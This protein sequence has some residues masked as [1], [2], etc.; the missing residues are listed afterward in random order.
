[1]H[2]AHAAGVVLEGCD[3]VGGGGPEQHG[4]VALDP[5]RVVGR[6]AEVLDSVG[7]ERGFRAR[8][9]VAQPEVVVADEGGLRAVGGRDGVGV[10]V[11]ARFV[12]FAGVGGE[13]A[14][15]P[16]LPRLR[17]E[18]VGLGAQL[19]GAE[20]EGEGL[21]RVAGDGADGR[22]QA[23]VVEGAGAGAGG[24]AD[25]DELGTVRGRVAVP[26]AVA[27]KP[28]GLHGRAE[29]EAAGAAG[30]ERLG[31]R[32]VLRRDGDGRL[33]GGDLFGEANEAETAVTVDR[34]AGRD[35]VGPSASRLH[36]LDRPP[37]LS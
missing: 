28:V 1:M 17:G 10:G 4:G 14:L 25:E 13:I 7:G 26:E 6:V 3:H 35:G 5:P 9:Q 18:A 16:H 24:G 8:V 27:G 11:R 32:V 20:G 33:L 23:V 36:V 21:D 29:D 12:G 19:E 22:G 37:Q 34:G 15:Q 30:E 2:H 31:A